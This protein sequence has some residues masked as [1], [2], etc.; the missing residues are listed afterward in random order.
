MCVGVVLNA[1]LWPVV[2]KKE[3][4]LC[5]LI[6]VGPWWET[7]LLRQGRPD[8]GENHFLFSV[9]GGQNIFSPLT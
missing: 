4:R 1:R 6:T 3:H 9:N 7:V 5:R 2:E 8:L